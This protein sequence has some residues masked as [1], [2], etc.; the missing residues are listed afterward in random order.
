VIPYEHLAIVVSIGQEICGG[1]TLCV[2]DF[3][4]DGDGGED[5]GSGGGINSVGVCSVGGIGSGK[6]NQCCCRCCCS[7][8]FFH[9]CRCCLDLLVRWHDCDYRCISENKGQMSTCRGDVIE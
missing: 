3:T 2:S 5:G 9:G 1:W 7:F 6:H 8:S 4:I